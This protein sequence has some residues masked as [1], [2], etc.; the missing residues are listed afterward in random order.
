MTSKRSSSNSNSGAA[1][2]PLSHYNDQ[3]VRERWPV[4]VYRLQS[5]RG[6]EVYSDPDKEAAATASSSSAPS[7]SKKTNAAAN[8]S[9]KGGNGGGAV[10]NNGVNDAPSSSKDPR[11]SEELTVAPRE[12]C[13]EVRKM[14]LRIQL[15]DQHT[16]WDPNR[17]LRPRDEEEANPNGDDDGGAPGADGWNDNSLIVRRRDT[18]LVTTRR[19]MGAVVFRFESTRDCVDFCDR[20]TY[21]NRE[22]LAPS[23]RGG[24]GA[25]D[26]SVPSARKR[27]AAGD[28][29]YVNGMDE[30]ES[31]VDGTRDEKRRKCRAADEG[32][33]VVRETSEESAQGQRREEIM[34]YI[35]RL[36]HDEEFRGFVDELERGLESASDTAALTAAFGA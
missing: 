26:V 34:S 15:F 12:G 2:A 5:H 33:V 19:G 20:L 18:L 22:R 27:A 1:S 23:S 28:G 10:N 35:V 7:G 9:T 3:G 4:L 11:A 30:R 16:P 6:W 29:G 8:K 14:R 25:E 13:I 24:D 17:P 31:R 32:V 36:A 21:L